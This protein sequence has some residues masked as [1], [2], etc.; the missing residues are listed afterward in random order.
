MAAPAA[1]MPSSSTSAAA[2]ASPAPAAAAGAG[3]GAAVG[4]ESGS[5]TDSAAAANK[6]RSAPRTV[7]RTDSGDF[8]GD[9]REP[10][11]ERADDASGQQQ[12]AGS[13][14]DAGIG[15]GDS[16]LGAL[17]KLHNYINSS[18]PMSA[19]AMLAKVGLD[20][21]G[22]IG[23]AEFVEALLRAGISRPAADLREMLDGVE[24]TTA[25]PAT[26]G[27]LEVFTEL[28]CAGNI[29]AAML[30]RALATI[31]TH[32]NL[33]RTT[34]A[35]VFNEIDADGSGELD[36]DE[37]IGALSKFGITTLSRPTVQ[38]IMLALDQDGDGGINVSAR[39]S[40]RVVCCSRHATAVAPG[41]YPINA[42]APLLPRFLITVGP[43][44]DQ[45][46]EMAATI[47]KFR[48]D[49]RSFAAAVLEQVWLR[50]RKGRA[51]G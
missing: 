33:H 17:T 35:A 8:R 10:A 11:G 29:V 37:M 14:A 32:L 34:A 41:C 42:R 39:L 25:G 9:A 31:C 22:T 40:A 45:V 44:M 15:E 46:A 49:R 48:R 20:G 18:A 21:S 47:D 24:L 28:A 23:T 38:S 36:V 2:A 26:V 4:A 16:A 5:S 27:V 19:E 12:A 7:A 43:L 3:A 1:A 13:M 50:V 30:D 6:L 51:C